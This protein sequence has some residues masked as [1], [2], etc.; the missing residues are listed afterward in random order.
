MPRLKRPKLRGL[1]R[2]SRKCRPT[3][4]PCDGISCGE[5]FIC[6]LLEI[7]NL[8]S[9]A[10]MMANQGILVYSVPS[11]KWP[12]SPFDIRLLK[13]QPNLEPSGSLTPFKLSILVPH[14]K[15]CGKIKS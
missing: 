3:K 15:L 7:I 2:E 14:Y 8:E 10:L 1:S 12:N 6:D 9:D 11:K 4:I 13:A 5:K